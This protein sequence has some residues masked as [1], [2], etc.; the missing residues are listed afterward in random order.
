M[1]KFVGE[2]RSKLDDKGRLVFPSA[3]KSLMDKEPLRF[4]VK[5]DLF[6]D[7]LS[8][9]TYSEWERESEEIKSKLNFF[10]KEHS[11]F[12]RGYMNNRA[13]IEPDEKLGRITIPRQLLDSINVKK[14][15]VFSGNDHKIE[16]WAKENYDSSTIGEDEFISLA[17]KI[18]GQ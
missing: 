11:K 17:E 3:F 18:L 2:Y 10:N 12:W 5:H 7:C 9:Y 14:E 6:S 13:L 4:V 8:I 16:L 15:V 1:V